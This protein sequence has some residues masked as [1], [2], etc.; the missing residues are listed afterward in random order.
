MSFFRDEESDVRNLWGRVAYVLIHEIMHRLEH[1]KFAAF[2]RS[3]WDS[4]ESVTLKEGVPTLTGDIVWAYVIARLP[5]IG[6]RGRTNLENWSRI[7][8]QADPGD[9]VPGTHEVWEQSLPHRYEAEAEAIRLVSQIGIENLLAAF[10]RGEWWKIVGPAPG[11]RGSL[12]TPG[13]PSEPPAEQPV[14]SSQRRPHRLRRR[15]GSVIS[16]SVVARSVV[17]RSEPSAGAATVQTS[18]ACVRSAPAASTE[19]FD[20]HLVPVERDWPGVGAS[21]RRRSALVARARWRH[22]Q[23]SGQPDIR[24]R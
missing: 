11:S 6:D 24:R 17:S 1:P 20:R 22:R 21:R 12:L 2:G 9:A 16:R 3:F 10:F 7:V 13:D 14:P 19:P 4:P 15:P 5:E 8:L 18:Y 23:P